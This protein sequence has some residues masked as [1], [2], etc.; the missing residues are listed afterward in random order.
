MTLNTESG[1]PKIYKSTEKLKFLHHSLDL[2]DT[3]LLRIKAAIFSTIILAC[4]VTNPNEGFALPVVI[5]WQV[6]LTGSHKYQLE[7]ASDPG[8]GN[9]VQTAQV[10]GKSQ[11][12]EAPTEG[13]Y[14][15]R[16]MRLGKTASASEAST[17]VSGSFI[18]VDP[19]LD[20]TRPA[21]IS[22]DRVERADSYKIYAVDRNGK[23]RTMIAM[24][25]SFVLPKV[26][27]PVMLEVV[28]YSGNAR[29]LRDYH[30]NPSLRWDSGIDAKEDAPPP[31]VAAPVEQQPAAVVATA[32]TPVVEEASSAPTVEKSVSPGLA[33]ESPPPEIP[34]QETPT[35][36]E[37]EPV[38]T[39]SVPAPADPEEKARRRK[40]Q[41]SFFLFHGQEK[42]RLQK[43]EV[44]FSSLEQV[45]G[46]G[47]SLWVNPTS[48]LLVSG[49]GWYH[50]HKGSTTQRSLFGDE[51]I[52]IDQAR[53]LVDL[54]VGWNLLHWTSLDRQIL[55]VSF[56]SAAAQMPFM[57]FEFDASAGELP[58]LRKK[59]VSMAGAAAGYSWQ[60]TTLGLSL[61]GG[62]LQE[63]SDDVELGFQ[64]LVFDYFFS[65]RIAL[66]VGFY[67]RF[68]R[69]SRCHSSALICLKEGKVVS[70]SEERGAY[71][72][73]GA[74]FF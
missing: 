31:V 52:E 73:V 53:Y 45:S 2:A 39:E 38:V 47:A 42:L 26:D 24:S 67:N 65:E 35:P 16:L 55:H 20:R 59:Q 46:V 48:G 50:E 10:Q 61:D 7:V 3:I 4:L 9:I 51:K 64:K 68:L 54:M 19:S 11:S 27:A 66:S 29:T 17:F 33:E 58:V 13:V 44:A 37:A 14:H 28:P 8:F 32:P 41:L 63:K 71:L 60:S 56:M 12:W 69:S 6:P 1:A 25:N 70:T 5:G 40:Y 49:S 72:G 74:A 15:W 22:W 36:V 18:A 21:K 62:F 57:P 43:L 30:F 34:V 23:A